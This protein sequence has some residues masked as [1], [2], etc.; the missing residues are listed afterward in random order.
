ML[1]GFDWSGV[2]AAG[3]AVMGA[4]L[5]VP[6][7]GAAAPRPAW[8]NAPPKTPEVRLKEYYHCAEFERNETWVNYYGWG[9]TQ[10]HSP[11]YDS[12]LD[13]FFVGLT[14]EQALLKIRHL[15]SVLLANKSKWRN[16]MSAVRLLRPQR[17]S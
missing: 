4:L 1:D 14:A 13:L 10:A 5:P 12:D 8:H 15:H 16:V 2:V 6:D 3:G 11:F 17:V 9:N 7:L